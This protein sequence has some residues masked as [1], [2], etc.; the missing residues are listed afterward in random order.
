MQQLNNLSV[1]TG[2]VGTDSVRELKILV[3]EYKTNYNIMYF[4]IVFNFTDFYLYT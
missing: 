4:T 3:F 1:R 2:K